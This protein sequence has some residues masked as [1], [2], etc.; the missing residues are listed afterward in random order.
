MYA[1]EPIALKKSGFSLQSEFLLIAKCRDGRD[2]SHDTYVKQML[3]FIKLIF[4][5][6]CVCVF[7]Y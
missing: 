7:L 4:L 1:T 3:I 2:W 6:M 5:Q